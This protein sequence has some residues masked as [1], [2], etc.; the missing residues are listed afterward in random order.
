MSH[1][2]ITDL[3]GT[4]LKNDA[5]LSEFTRKTLEGLILDGVNISLATARSIVSVRQ[6]FGD[7]KIRLPVICSNGAYISDPATGLHRSVQSIPKPRD[8]KVLEVMKQAGFNPFICTYDNGN[9]HLYLEQKL[10]EGMRIYRQD[11]IQTGD[12]RLRA[13]ED[14]RHIM[15]ESV[16]CLNVID[17]I[18]PLEELKEEVERLFPGQFQAYIY[19]NIYET[20]WHWY[21]VYDQHS[22]KARAVEMLVSELGYTTDNVT[23]FGDNLNDISMFEV[24][25]NKV[26]TGNAKE[27]LKR[28]ASE[29][30]GTN[31]EDSVVKY[32]LG[33]V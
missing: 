14:A 12:H 9:D 25:G 31:E 32:I 21:S 26:A 10:N 16:I 6:I 22:T 1:L 15:H 11:R 4:L 2:F 20:D 13:V 29:V 27:E 8:M 17:R 24:A 28:L 3:D 19:E 23:V 33:K 18:E 30:I 7:L 5:T